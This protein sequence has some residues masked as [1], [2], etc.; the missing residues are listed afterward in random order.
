MADRINALIYS[1]LFGIFLSVGAM[2]IFIALFRNRKSPFLNPQVFAILLVI[3]ILKVTG[4]PY[5]AYDI[6]GRVISFFLGPVTV[7]LAVPLYKQLDKLKA[8][9]L[10]VLVGIL[11]GTLVAIFSS[12]SLAIAFGLSRQLIYGLG[13]KSVT[14]AIATDLSQALGGNPSL[15]FALVFATGTFG[16]IVGEKVLNL[17]RVKSPVARGLALGTASHAFGTMSALSMGEVEG[18]MSSLALSVAGV[19]TT[20]L[21]PVI[22]RLYG[23]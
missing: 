11:A 17:S 3:G 22:L 15:T 20:F 8:N 6:G 19:I 12:I 18:A 5:Q 2:A 1:P 21:L 23:Y 14:S 13:A 4:I 7:A 16:G 10:P 9:A